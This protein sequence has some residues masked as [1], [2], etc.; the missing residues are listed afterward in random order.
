VVEHVGQELLYNLCTSILKQEHFLVVL[1]LSPLCM[2][3]E[4]ASAEC[5]D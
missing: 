3:I 1:E 5:A 4:E 2:Q